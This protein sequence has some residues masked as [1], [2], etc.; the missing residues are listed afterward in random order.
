MNRQTIITGLKAAGSAATAI[1]VASL[2]SLPY[3]ATAGIIAILSL[4]GTKRETL[5]VALGRLMAY[6]S[7]LVIA[8][9][10]FFLLGDGLLAFGV[11][12]FLFAALCYACSWGYATAMVSVLISHFMGTGGMTWTQVGNETLL[13]LIGT[14]CGIVT[15][16]H[17]RPDEKQLKTLLE[18]ADNGMRQA[19][20]ALSGENGA[21]VAMDV[22]QTLEKTLQ[23]AASCA[24]R[25]AGNSLVGAP[26]IEIRYIAMRQQQQRVLT[27]MVQDWA[28]LREHPAQEEKVR[29]FMAQVATEYHLNNSVLS[30][31]EDLHALLRQMQEQPLPKAREE[32]ENRALLYGIL[33]RMEDFLMLKRTF[34]LENV[35]DA[36]D[37]ANLI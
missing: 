22:L 30:L 2:L 9:A 25:N 13:F 8:F 23:E 1:L 10:C 20:R 34:Y 7:A 4:M 32:F 35:R 3:S 11:Y 27:Q 19:L 26:V 5:K 37:T 17:L 24:E 36:D 18:Q 14:T 6:A 29:A 12:L 28:K 33:R 16:L 21:Q 31:L 15:N